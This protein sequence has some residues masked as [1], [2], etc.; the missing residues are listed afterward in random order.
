MRVVNR[1][2]ATLTN[3][4]VRIGGSYTRSTLTTPPTASGANILPADYTI[5]LAPGQQQNINLGWQIDL[6]QYNYE[7]TVTVTAVDFT[8]PNTG[9]NSYKESFLAPPT[10]V[11]QSDITPTDCFVDSPKGTLWYR[12][13]NRGPAVLTNKRIT[14]SITAEAH[15]YNPPHTVTSAHATGIETVS[16]PT[17][18]DFT[19]NSGISVDTTTYWYKFTVTVSAMDFSDPNANNNSYSETIPPPP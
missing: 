14:V 5:S 6:T 3:K 18:Q 1:G 12:V 9:N 17:G 15:M 19:I 11:P 13:N 2:P 10:P 4:K 7:F 8:D 16:I